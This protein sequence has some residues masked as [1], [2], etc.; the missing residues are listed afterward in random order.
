VKVAFILKK[1]ADAEKIEVSS[2]EMIAEAQIMA[3]R[4]NMPVQ[5]LIEK[6]REGQGLSALHED[7]VS[8]KTIDFILQSATIE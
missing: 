6:L 2:E 5:K 1:I 4:Y 8:R 7:L 3:Q